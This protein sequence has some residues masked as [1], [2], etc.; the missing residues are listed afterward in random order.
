M[1]TDQPLPVPVGSRWRHRKGGEYVV[2]GLCRDEES[3]A[4]RVIYVEDD[5][6]PRSDPPWGWLL[7]VF[8]DG[9]FERL[10]DVEPVSGLAERLREVT[11][12]RD[13]LSGIVS[14]LLASV[15]APSIWQVKVGDVMF[16][17]DSAHSDVIANRLRAELARMLGQG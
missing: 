3:G 12:D 5:H 15:T 17:L 16:S 7:S 11:A 8:T 14:R 2:V 1:T 9:R 10:P 6:R 4:I 13:R